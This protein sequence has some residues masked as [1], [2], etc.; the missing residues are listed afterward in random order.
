MVLENISTSS[1]VSLK[2]GFNCVIGSYLKENYDEIN[3]L[4]HYIIHT[5][6]FAE[7]D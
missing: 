2:I 1:L 7:K 5:I 4:Q 3:P 6:D